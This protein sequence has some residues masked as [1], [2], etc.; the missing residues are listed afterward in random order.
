MCLNLDFFWFN[1]QVHICR[2]WVITHTLCS[3]DRHWSLP[4]YGNKSGRD[5]TQESGSASIWWVANLYIQHEYFHTFHSHPVILWFS[6][7]I[8][9]SLLPSLTAA[10]MWRSQSTFR[11]LCPARPPVYP[12][13][14]SAGW[15]MVE[16]SILTRTR[17]CTGWSRFSPSLFSNSRLKRQNWNWKRTFL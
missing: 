16:P 10:P 2:G 5:A 1:M 4:L 15:K 8:F 6:A 3:G 9:Q 7:L 13:P 11:P 12:N 14:P 17:I